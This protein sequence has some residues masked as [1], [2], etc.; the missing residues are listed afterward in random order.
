MK[1][2]TLVSTIYNEAS[3]LQDSIADIENQTLKPD[4]VVIVDAGSNDGTLKILDE[5]RKK[6]SSDIKIIIE[7]KCNVAR[8]RNMAIEN[9]THD[10]IVST[11]F[12]C[13]YE[14]RWL[15]SL[16]EKFNSDSVQVVGGNFSIREEDINTLS[17][18]AAYLLAGGYENDIKGFVPSSRSIAYYKSVWENVGRYP[19]WLTL[20]G[21]DTYF[22]HQLIAKGHKIHHVKEPLVFW[23]RH[24]DF[25]AYDKE[26]FRYG[27]GDGESKDPL[28]RRN[29]IVKTFELILRVVFIISI[30]INIANGW[31]AWSVI[32]MVLSVAGFRPYIH[33][34]KNWLKL[35]SKKY[36]IKSLMMAFLML[37]TNRWN[38]LKGYVKGYTKK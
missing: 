3:R 28:N 12:G 6:S 25:K 32:L 8:G 37:E 11:D 34:I 9:A 21:D 2:F 38:Y 14:K 36:G 31:M 1:K 13:R 16:L 29:I 5:W 27:L 7:E 19:E 24:K 10:L 26:A 4:E 30:V 23:G 33:L 35:R 22:G 15:E 18:R 20:A 17:A